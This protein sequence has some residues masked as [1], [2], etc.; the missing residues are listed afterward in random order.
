MA[1][2]VEGEA[3]KRM[4]GASAQGNTTLTGLA[5]GWLAGRGRGNSGSNKT[6]GKTAADWENEAVAADLEFGRQGTR[7]SWMKED[8]E[9]HGRTKSMAY[10][11][12]GSA[13]WEAYQAPSGRTGVKA[14]GAKQTPSGTSGN[15]KGAQFK[16]TVGK[17]AKEAAVDAGGAIAGAAATAIT[18]NPAVGAAAATLGSEAVKAGINKVSARRNKNTTV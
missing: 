8:I 11:A 6:P 16:S 3:L 9:Q 17:V 7:R 4:S 12:D 13:K 5:T 14:G 1:T 2:N 15:T 18:K 10:G